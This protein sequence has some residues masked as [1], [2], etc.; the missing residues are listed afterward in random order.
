MPEL[1]PSYLNDIE[2][3]RTLM[4]NDCKIRLNIKNE[5]CSENISEAQCS[6][7]SITM[8]S[9]HDSIKMRN[10]KKSEELVILTIKSG[11]SKELY[12]IQQ[13]F[14]KILQINGTVKNCIV[15]QCPSLYKMYNDDCECIINKIEL[16]CKHWNVRC[17]NIG[18]N[19]NLFSSFFTYCIKYIWFC[20]V[21]Q[22]Y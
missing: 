18:K 21:T 6:L 16:F 8:N 3:R 13:Y 4:I 9:G 7:N 19:K 17:I 20:D 2:T 11:S 15:L 5:T 12:Q 10:I 22:N 14:D 1:R